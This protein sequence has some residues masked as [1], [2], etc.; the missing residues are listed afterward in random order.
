VARLRRS[1]LDK[2]GLRRAGTG[3]RTRLLG[4]DGTRVDDQETLDRVAALA[5]PP[6]WS[7]VWIAPNPRDHIQATGIDAAGRKQY[8]YHSAWRADQDREKFDRMLHLAASLPR[9]R[10]AVTADLR[11]PGLEANRVLAGAFRLLDRGSL[12]IG[13]E[14]YADAYGSF[15]LSTILVRHVKVDDRDHV[16]LRFPGKS[17]QAWSSEFVDRDLARLLREL[18]L[19]GPR[20]RLLSWRDDTGTWHRLTPA[21][22]N[23][24]VRRRTGLDVT[25]KDFRTLRGSAVAAASLASHG[26]ETTPAGQRRAIAGALQLVAQELGNTPAIARKSYV[27]PRILDR[28]AAGEVAHLGRG[29]SLESALRS[30][31][32]G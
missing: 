23:A 31:L 14:Q 26:V 24:D 4:V 17:G 32:L 11:T 28:Y 29:V 22:I 30:F 15:G 10:R 2:P 8:L 21:M 3:R 25:A 20:Q 7:D 18:T 27:D 1:Q 16:R 13:G 19:R 6:A 9:A 12:R 5:I